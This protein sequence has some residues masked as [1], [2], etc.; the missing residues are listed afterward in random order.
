[1][2]LR[3]LPVESSVLSLVACLLIA[4][5]TTI[6]QDGRPTIPD[7]LRQAG[8]SLSGFSTVPSGPTHTMTEVLADTDS[9]VRGILGDPQSYLSED[10]K[11]VYTDYQILD[12]IFLYQSNLVTSIQPG[13]MPNVKVTIHGGTIALGAFTYT[14]IDQ[15]L[16]PLK[17]GG[18]YLIL[19]RQDGEKYR[20]AG[21]YLGVFSITDGKLTPV[22]GRSDFAPES[23]G[24]VATEVAADIVVRLSRPR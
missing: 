23:R 24:A 20:I 12:P 4:G 19:L 9:V 13:I 21:K 1:M 17:S 10:Q 22:T 16:P 6:A 18:E 5:A 14:F 2:N 7:V 8:K 3:N 11:D 15:A